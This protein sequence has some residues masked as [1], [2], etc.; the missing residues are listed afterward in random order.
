M[1]QRDPHCTLQGLGSA[2]N[3]M[4]H[5]SNLGEGEVDPSALLGFPMGL[6]K[7]FAEANWIAGVE[8]KG[9]KMTSGHSS[10]SVEDHCPSAHGRAMEKASQSGL[11]SRCIRLGKTL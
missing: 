11:Q 2:A 9:S 10:Q 7:S 4:W 8:S 6:T 5:M 3:G 1:A